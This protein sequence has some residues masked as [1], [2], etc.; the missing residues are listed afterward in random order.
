MTAL[1]EKPARNGALLR[2]I[3]GISQK[4]L[5]QTLKELERNNLIERRD[6]GTVPP[7]VEYRL[8]TLGR[9]L[10]DALVVLDRWAERHFP[11][12]DLARERYDAARRDP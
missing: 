5:T 4:V 2:K 8:S 6:L 9:S 11:E 10:G 1:A 3:G 7:H 12:L